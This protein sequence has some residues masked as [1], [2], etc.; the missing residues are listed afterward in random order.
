MQQVRRPLR[1]TTD[2]AAAQTRQMP[3]PAPASSNPD[4]GMRI[5]RPGRAYRGSGHAW[6]QTAAVTVDL[7]VAGHRQCPTQALRRLPAA[8]FTTALPSFTD[9]DTSSET[10]TAQKLHNNWSTPKVVHALKVTRPNLPTYFTSRCHG[11]RVCLK[12]TRICHLPCSRF[13]PA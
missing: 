4:Q 5:R 12:R 7:E 2:D 13:R 11:L 8:T 9:T 6:R 10:V 1:Q 3:L